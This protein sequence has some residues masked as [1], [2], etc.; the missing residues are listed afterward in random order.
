[1]ATFLGVHDMGK[2]MTD[3]EIKSVWD[4]YK[5]ACDKLGCSGMHVHYSGEKGRSYCL[6]EADSADEVQKAHDEAK[7]PVN[8]ILEVKTLE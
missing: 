2:A 7:V 4:S 3:D 5:A 1:M 8:E 6:T